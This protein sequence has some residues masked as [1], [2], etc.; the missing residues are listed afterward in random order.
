MAKPPKTTNF[1]Y[2]DPAEPRTQRIIQA[3]LTVNVPWHPEDPPVYQP[4][5]VAE[6]ADRIEARADEGLT[7]QLKPETARMVAL[8]LRVCGAGHGALSK[9]HPHHVE[10][11]SHGIPEVLAYC[12]S[13][14][15]ANGAWEAYAPQYPERKL[16]ATWGGWI[17]RG[18]K[19]A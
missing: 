19:R 6:L 15:L 10:D 1:E 2:L 18:N 7:V 16:I 8:A 9:T 5:K 4:S 12:T 3:A 14:T 13:A 17:T 11:W